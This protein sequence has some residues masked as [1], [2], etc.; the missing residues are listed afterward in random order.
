[1]ISEAN[2]LTEN[3]RKHPRFMFL[4][5]W[6]YFFLHAFLKNPLGVYQIGF[7]YSINTER[8]KNM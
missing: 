2:K 8:L 7:V 1:M 5:L 3:K 4:E 6:K